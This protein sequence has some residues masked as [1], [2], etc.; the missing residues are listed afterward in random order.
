MV[1]WDWLII[2][3]RILE[4][5]ADGM[6]KPQTVAKAASMFHISENVIWKHVEF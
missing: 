2:I 3:A 6:S 5:I 4:L 1:I